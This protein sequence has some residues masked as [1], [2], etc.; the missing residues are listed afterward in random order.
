MALSR[1]NHSRWYIYEQ[2][3]SLCVCGDGNLSIE[4]LSADF[5][6]AL[7]QFKMHSTPLD[8]LIL[9]KYVKDWLLVNQEKISNK[10]YKQRIEKLRNFE[11]RRCYF[12]YGDSELYL[13]SVDKNIN[14]NERINNIKDSKKQS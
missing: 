2:D 5:D 4:E 1:W 7:D 8:F 13:R 11:Y 3:N 14:A 9:K 6:K 10:E 12:N